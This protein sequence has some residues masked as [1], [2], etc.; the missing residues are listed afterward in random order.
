[1]PVFLYVSEPR[2]SY[3][4]DRAP[5]SESLNCRRS[6]S[7]HIHLAQSAFECRLVHLFAVFAFDIVPT[8][9]IAF[10]EN[11]RQHVFSRRDVRSV[12]S[13]GMNAPC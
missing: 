11:R 12:K 7:F 2:M 5:L 8:A 9:P 4:L 3:Q 13:F 1:M 10:F 6:C